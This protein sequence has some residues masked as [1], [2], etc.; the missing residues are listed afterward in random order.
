MSDVVD[1]RTG[2]PI[3]ANYNPIPTDIRL[4][5]LGLALWDAGD[6]LVGLAN[7]IE[8]NAPA[9]P[10]NLSTLMQLARDLRTISRLAL[11]HRD[12]A[13]AKREESLKGNGVI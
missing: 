5:N 8:K 1:F 7:S 9:L 4:A 12:L 10:N 13:I 3:P 11:A 6:S 2:K